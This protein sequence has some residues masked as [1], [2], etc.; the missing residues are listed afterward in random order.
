VIGYWTFKKGNQR[1]RRNFLIKSASI[2][3]EEE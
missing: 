3:K 1:M 2:F